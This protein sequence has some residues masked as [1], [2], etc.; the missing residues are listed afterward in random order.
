M[1]F[2][3][4]EDVSIEYEEGGVVRVKQVGKVVIARGPWPVIA[5]LYREQ[6]PDAGHYGNLKVSLM[7]FRKE[8]G[9]YRLES[10][11]NITS[12]DQAA[13]I[14]SVLQGW[15]SEEGLDA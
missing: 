3:D 5:F 7:K 1:W 12:L 9:A 8:H 10:R 6:D 14:A 4:I 11:F 15:A 13:K 2:E